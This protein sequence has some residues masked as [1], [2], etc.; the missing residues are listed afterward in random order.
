MYTARAQL[1]VDGANTRALFALGVIERSRG[2]LDRARALLARETA[3]DPRNLTALLLLG[4]VVMSQGDAEA[5]AEVFE[6]ALALD[7][8]SLEARLGRGWASLI[9]GRREEAAA[10]WRPVAGSARD[11]ATLEAMVKLYRSLGDREAE[12]AAAAGLA[13]A[14]G[15]R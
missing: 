6:R 2:R 4:D 12:A 1:L 3:L 14:R 15:A 5:G 7:P 8:A 9:A 10:W 11:A 13:R